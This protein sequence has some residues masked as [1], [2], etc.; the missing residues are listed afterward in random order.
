VGGTLVT[1]IAVVLLAPVLQK[2]QPRKLR[3]CVLTLRMRTACIAGL[4]A[5]A[6]YVNLL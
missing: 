5:G 2:M 4:R 6:P 3:A 1:A